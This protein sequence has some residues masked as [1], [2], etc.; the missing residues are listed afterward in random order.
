MC[1]CEGLL[2]PKAQ[3]FVKMM[4]TVSDFEICGSWNKGAVD[5]R[6][7]LCHI[8]ETSDTVL[9]FSALKG[10]IYCI[11]ILLQ[12]FIE[13]TISKC[14]SEMAWSQ[15]SSLQSAVHTLSPS[16]FLL[17]S[18]NAWKHLYLWMFC[19]QHSSSLISP[20]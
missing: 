3:K 20:C 11:S 2:I 12:L 4:T 5:T 1:L 15:L 13:L 14:T 19:L 18:K 17:V 8:K 9:Y 6:V 10:R 16:V 7:S